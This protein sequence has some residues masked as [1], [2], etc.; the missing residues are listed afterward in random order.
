[1]KSY[2]VYLNR[3]DKTDLINFFRNIANDSI[4]FSIQF[5]AW[6]V[7]NDEPVKLYAYEIIHGCALLKKAGLENSRLY[8]ILSYYLG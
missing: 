1:M 2:S 4:A 8:N 6:N 5:S 7:G 3:T